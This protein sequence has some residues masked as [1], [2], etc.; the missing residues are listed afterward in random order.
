MVWSNKDQ[1]SETW[2]NSKTD[3]DGQEARGRAMLI[4][5]AQLGI[6]NHLFRYWDQMR[7]FSWTTYKSILL[8]SKTFESNQFSANKMV[9]LSIK[10]CKFVCNCSIMVEAYTI[11]NVNR[12]NLNRI[13]IQTSAKLPIYTSSYCRHESWK[14]KTVH[15][16]K[17]WGQLGRQ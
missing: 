8:P 15:E 10:L 3:V 5:S 17:K 11:K 6:L 12:I 1:I 14:L 4:V 13:K 16:Q 9:A 2:S 7:F